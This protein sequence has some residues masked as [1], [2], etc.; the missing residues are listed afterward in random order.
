[1]PADGRGETPSSPVKLPPLQPEREPR[2]PL[3]VV[4]EGSK[5]SETATKYQVS[6]VRHPH[7]ETC[8]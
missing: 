2:L 7:G 5:M 4:A 3:Q 8:E 6:P 1:M